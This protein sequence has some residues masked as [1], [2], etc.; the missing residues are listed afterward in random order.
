MRPTGRFRFGGAVVAVAVAFAAFLPG[1]AVAAT[2]PP[3]ISTSFGAA[4]IPLKGSTSLSYRIGNPNFG[5]SLSQV[6]FTDELPTGLVL[7]TPNGPSNDCGGTVTAAAG[8][9]NV[10]LSGGSLSPGSQCA[11]SVNVTGTWGGQKHNSVTVSTG[12]GLTGNTST[13]TVTVTVPARERV[14]WTN[15]DNSISFV[16]LDGSGGGDLTTTGA[17]MD[18]P[19][20]VA[21][22]PAAGKIYWANYGNGSISYANLDGS[23]GG[24][25]VTTGATVSYPRGWRSTPPP[26]RSTGPTQ[27][28]LD[29]V[30]QPRRQRRRRPGHDRRRREG[31]VGVALDPA[32][33]KIYWA[34]TGGKLDL[35]RQPQRHRRRQPEHDRRPRGR[36]AR[37]GA[38]PRRRQDLLGPTSKTRS[39]TPTSTAPAARPHYQAGRGIGVWRSIPRP[40]GSTGPTPRFQLDLLR[41]PRPRRRRLPD[42]ALPRKPFPCA[43]EASGRGGRARG[44][45]RLRWSVLSC[46]QGRWAPDLVGSFLYRAPHSF[47]YRWSVNGAAISGATASTYTASGPGDYR[48]RVTA[49]NA[50]GGTSQT[51]APHTVAAPPRCPGSHRP[52][53]L[54]AAPS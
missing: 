36:A 11:I 26:A 4:S 30:R 6:N 13:A 27:R 20:G 14:Y 31:P 40:G 7:A 49:S 38:R 32:A 42:G 5:T 22:D 39:R 8:S 1:S 54:R 18:F 51:S 10:S 23:G 2:M 37:G 41:R 45:R 15:S 12:S 47:A 28:Q 3:T 50:A 48:C 33:G 24:D 25:L 35:V 53:G 21:L 52:A 19:Q 44:H 34:N 17:T 46:S 16:N 29:L 9:S 43:A